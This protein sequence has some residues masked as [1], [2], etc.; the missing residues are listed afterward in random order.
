MTTP[1][2]D[3]D[4]IRTAL[5]TVLD[6]ELGKSITELSMV[7]S[8]DIHDEGLVKVTLLLTTPTCPL[9]SWFDHEITEA[10]MGVEGVESVEVIMGDMN[11]TQREQLRSSL[12]RSPHENPFN[13]GDNPTRVI[14][15]ASGKGGVGKSSLSVN[16]AVTLAQQGYSVGLID[17]DIYGH[18]VADLLGIPEDATLTTIE[19]IDTVLPLQA[20]GI[21]VMSIARMK[22]S[23]DQVIAWRGPIVEKALS[24]FFTDIQW[25]NPDFLVVD[26]PP[27]TGDIAIGFGQRLPN[28]EVIVVTTPQV[29]AT[30]I[31][32]RA[33]SM[34]ATLKQKV[35]GVVE[36]MSHLETQCP[37][38]QETCRIEVFGQGGGTTVSENLTQQLGYE[39]PLLAQIPFDISFREEADQGIPGVV[40]SPAT[41][42]ASAISS[43]AEKIASQPRNPIMNHLSRAPSKA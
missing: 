24:Q 1:Q 3:L 16:L 25:G 15:V 37:H 11:E 41:P 38:C 18:S 13:R 34:A 36:N 39:V 35:I 6:P 23:R 32:Q 12:Y 30:D 43:L 19:E 9:K 17:A 27:G 42:T 29:A 40:S 4:Q 8:I 20:H 5:S 22:P 26:L 21:K 7:D 28:A 10:V 33:G 2:P 14:G 31:A